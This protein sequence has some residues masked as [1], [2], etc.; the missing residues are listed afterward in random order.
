M[1]RLV[2]RL[3]YGILAV[4]L[5][6]A[7]VWGFWPQP[8]PID[9][10]IVGREALR[11]TVDEDGKTRI[12]EKYVVSAPLTGQLMRIDLHAGDAVR[13]G[14]TLLARIE[15][16]DPTLLDAR[17]QVGG[18]ARVRS[19]EATVQQAEAALSRAA[20]AL[21]LAQSELGRAQQ[22]AAEDAISRE[23][24][25]EKQI[26]RRTCEAEHKAAKFGHDIAQFELQQAKAALMRSDPNL[27]H[28]GGSPHFDIVSPVNGQVL[29]VLQESMT[30]VQPGMPLLE[31]GDPSDLEAEI[32]VLSTDAVK[33]H[34]GAS[35]SFEHWG[36]A[37]PLAGVVR[38]VE[39][40]AFTK[41]S[42]L[43]VEEQ[44]TNVIADFVDPPE[45][46][47]TLGD[48]FRVEARITV[49][50]GEEVLQV[51]TGASFREGDRW[52]VF[53]VREGRAE[54]RVIELGHRNDLDAEVLKGL[55][56]GDVVIVHPSDRIQD[57]TRVKSRRR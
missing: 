38:V 57:G 24:L 8:A 2:P 27:K 48:A 54:L 17:E 3:S 39:P 37:H 52:A 46:R 10:A 25:E 55:A 18:E 34:K 45:M 4:G 56:E 16:T 19:A 15:P 5:V 40:S 7:I 33:I 49:W 42:A 36:G 21:D 23:E 20:A 44:R 12:K 53:V 30:V 11:V 43:G 51:P 9:T 13:A 32:D 47:R 31:I 41:I 6:A 29:R 50:K 22:L 26:R 28:R 14:H 1:K 35:V